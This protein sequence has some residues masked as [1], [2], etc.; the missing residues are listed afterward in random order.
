VVII[1]I[2]MSVLEENDLLA[3][4]AVIGI[5]VYISYT[6]SDKLTREKFTRFSYR[7]N[8]WVNSRIHRRHPNKW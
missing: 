4:F 8:N 1:E 6:L 7:Y 5:T 2:I 3:A